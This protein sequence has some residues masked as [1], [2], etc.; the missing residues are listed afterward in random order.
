[1]HTD[2]QLMFQRR[3]LINIHCLFVPIY[4]PKVPCPTPLGDDR[5]CAVAARINWGSLFVPVLGSS[6]N[7]VKSSEASF[8]DQVRDER[9]LS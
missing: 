6:R 1:M 2:V 9:N 4:C 3:I 5:L 7:W 8:R